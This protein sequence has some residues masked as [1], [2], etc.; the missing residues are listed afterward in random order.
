MWRLIFIKEARCFEVKKAINHELEAHGYDGGEEEDEED[1]D[2]VC[3][4]VVCGQ[5]WGKE[6]EDE[7]VMI[8][9]GVVVI[10]PPIGAGTT[11]SRPLV[12]PT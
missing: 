1:D 5:Q 4:C 2:G 3:V 9:V 10:N 8:F 12:Y 7:S 6:G 11:L